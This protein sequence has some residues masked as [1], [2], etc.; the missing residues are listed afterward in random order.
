VNHNI[1][2]LDRFLEVSNCPTNRVQHHHAHIA[3][4]FAEHQYPL[5]TKPVLGIALDGLGFG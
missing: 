2:D 5:N 1:S 4:C 3:A